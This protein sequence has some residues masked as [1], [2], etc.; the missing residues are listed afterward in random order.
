MCLSN[1]GFVKSILREIVPPCVWRFAQGMYL[2]VAKR[3]GSV[4]WEGGYPDWRSAKIGRAS[5]R[6]RV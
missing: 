6:E 4:L 1:K 3:A 5:C 2:T